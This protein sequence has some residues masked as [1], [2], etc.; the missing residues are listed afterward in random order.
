MVRTTPPA[1]RECLFKNVCRICVKSRVSLSKLR[2]CFNCTVPLQG[3]NRVFVECDQHMWRLGERDLPEGV[4]VLS[5]EIF[6]ISV[7]EV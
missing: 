2:V 4:I 6:L 3:L 7:S 5:V 1:G